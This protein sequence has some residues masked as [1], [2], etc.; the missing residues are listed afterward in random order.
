MP[1]ELM[2]TEQ[3]ETRANAVLR[4]T[5]IKKMKSKKYI[6]KLVSIHI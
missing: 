6:Q 4:E 5:Q 1:W 2:H 3:F